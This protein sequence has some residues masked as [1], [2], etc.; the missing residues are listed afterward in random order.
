MA[1]PKS[2][3]PIKSRKIS[4]R[5]TE[6]DYMKIKSVY[7]SLQKF[8]DLMVKAVPIIALMSCNAPQT[9]SEVAR[10]TDTAQGKSYTSQG[11]IYAVAGWFQRSTDLAYKLSYQCDDYECLIDADLGSYLD[12]T[13]YNG[14]GYLS[15]YHVAQQTINKADGNFYQ[16][17]ICNGQNLCMDIRINFIT[18]YIAVSDGTNC[19][20][21]SKISTSEEY[22]SFVSSFTSNLTNSGYLKIWNTPESACGF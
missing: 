6:E 5:L 21:S 10:V 19:M 13:Q 11:A 14:T 7:G 1:R 4:L 12:N 3:D 22:N 17:Q 16:G 8:L 18:K 20:H 9:A 2:K 15:D